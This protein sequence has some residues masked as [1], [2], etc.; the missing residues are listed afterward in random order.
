[1]TYATA[2]APWILSHAIEIDRHCAGF[3]GELLRVSSERQHL[4]A[5]YLAAKPPSDGEHWE[6]ANFLLR[7]RHCE[8]LSAGYGEVPRGL[9][10]AL[11]RSG[12]VV[13][14]ERFYGLLHRLLTRGDNRIAKCIAQVPRLDL[15]TLIAI[16][17]L[18][19]AACSPNLVRAVMGEADA[20]DVATAFEVLVESGVDEEWLASDLREVK[21]QKALSSVFQKA[22]RR[23][24]APPHPVPPADF[25]HP[26]ETGEELFS[27][28]R[29]FRNC[30]RNYTC[31]LLDDA[32]GN[33]FAIASRGGHRTVVHLV[34]GPSGWKLEGLFKT[35]NRR[36][37]RPTRERIESYLK[38]HGVLV[39]SREPRK[40]S[41][42]DSVHNLIC[43]DLLDFQFGL[44][45]EELEETV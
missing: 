14:A 18:P 20:R 24:K 25:Y 33:A 27:V 44:E 6:A 41:R 23:A 37:S 17:V 15:N 30:L 10:R 22:A 16:E 21:T 4:I 43:A 34:R 19:S 3:C 1:M 32:Q 11:G 26:I 13:H 40:S 42:W 39:E 2:H 12:A 38:E 9:R 36:P 7:A 45:L 28:A 31:S 5:A 29:E 35:R 8:I